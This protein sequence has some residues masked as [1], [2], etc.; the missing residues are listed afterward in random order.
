MIGETLD[1]V[2][3]QTWAPITI[4]VVDDGSTEGTEQ[5]VERFRDRITYF[6]QPNA[7]LAAARNAGMAR[8]TGSYVAW[9]DSDD[10][11]EP[12]LV[13]SRRIEA[14][15]HLLASIGLGHVSSDT[16]RALVKM[17]LPRRP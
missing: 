6:R 13:G 11:W 17:F 15:R 7:G 1:S 10:I 5:A 2:L 8:A 16:A 12:A 3:A 4:I 14:A 9:L